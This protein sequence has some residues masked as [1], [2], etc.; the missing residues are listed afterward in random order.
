MEGGGAISKPTYIHILLASRVVDAT[1]TILSSDP[2]LVDLSTYSHQH[3]G[4]NVLFSS[5]QNN[6]TLTEVVGDHSHNIG[7]VPS[8]VVQLMAVESLASE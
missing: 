1:L 4:D 7:R 8:S 3:V 2:S 6:Q 5:L